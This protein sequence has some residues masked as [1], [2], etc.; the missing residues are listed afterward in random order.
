LKKDK[1]KTVQFG[2]LNA[3]AETITIQYLEG[4][5]NEYSSE[6]IKKK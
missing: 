6:T 2:F 5:H 4:F 1:N 3:A